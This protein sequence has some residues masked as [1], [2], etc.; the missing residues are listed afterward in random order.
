MAF[1]PASQHVLDLICLS[2]LP[3]LP[4]FFLAAFCLVAQSAAPLTSH[5]PPSAL[6]GDTCTSEERH[7]VLISGPGRVMGTIGETHKRCPAT[8][9]VQ[10]QLRRSEQHV[11]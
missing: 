4:F 9:A 8:V 2:L 3:S 7:W 5:S 10:T 11:C 6:L 1:A